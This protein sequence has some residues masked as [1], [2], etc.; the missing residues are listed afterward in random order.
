MAL[1]S[2]LR[3]RL[4]LPLVGSPLFVISTPDLVLAQCKAGIMGAFPA[5]NARPASLLDEWLHQIQEELTAW[6]KANPTRLAAPFAVNQIVHKTNNR[7]EQD[8]ALCV[9][10][11]VPVVITSLGAR[12]EINQ[13]VHSYGGVT[14]HDV[15]NNRFAHKAIEKG[16][17]GL[18]PVAAGGGGHAGTLSPFALMREIR[19]WFNGLV[20]LAGGIAH[21]ASVLAAL[22]CGADLAYAGSVFIATREA[23]APEDYKKMI[24][25]AAADDI[26]YTNLFTGVHGNYLKPSLVK[27]GWDPEN[28][29][30]SD[31]SKMNFGSGGNMEAKAWRDIWG[32]G[33]GIGVV[34]DVPSVAE[35]VD[36]LEREMTEARRELDLKLAKD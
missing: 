19:E 2:I 18:I 23:N 15:I 1:P 11:K 31:P 32:C 20:A 25:E 33:Q 27:A 14:L 7:L 5:L 6:D 10:H 30:A 16:A 29:P 13:A 36:R 35:V 24:V 26:V 4:R 22:A 34:H 28:L 8:L 3:G 9:K 21:G 12:E 17:D